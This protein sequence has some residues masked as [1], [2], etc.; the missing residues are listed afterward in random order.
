MRCLSGGEVRGCGIGVEKEIGE[1]RMDTRGNGGAEGVKGEEGEEVRTEKGDIGLV[2]G[3]VKVRNGER[4]KKGGE[5]WR[6]G[7]C[8]KKR[9]E[10]LRG[11]RVGGYR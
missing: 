5:T 2:G 9:K 3:G 7:R 4:R 10:K 11:K 8:R 1:K 6:K